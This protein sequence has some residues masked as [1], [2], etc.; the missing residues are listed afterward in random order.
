M[1]ETATGFKPIDDTDSFTQYAEGISDALR[2]S[3][4]PAESERPPLDLGVLYR[5]LSSVSS[6][7]LK[8]VISL[9]PGD[10]TRKQH[11]ARIAIANSFTHELQLVHRLFVRNEKDQILPDGER[12]NIIPLGDDMHA[13][14]RREQI[15]LVRDLQRIGAHDQAVRELGV[16]LLTKALVEGGLSSIAARWAILIGG[17]IDRHGNYDPSI[18]EFHEYTLVNG[19]KIR[20]LIRHSA[21]VKAS[22]LI[23][24]KTIGSRIITLVQTR[25]ASPFPELPPQAQAELLQ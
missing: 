14:P 7:A 6:R 10:E 19:K 9:R 22:D 5:D 4:D 21:E 25:P 16:Q 12:L 3:V 11:S 8:D 24:L 18:N 2:F 15:A 23:D 17:S 13:T 20:S 1:S